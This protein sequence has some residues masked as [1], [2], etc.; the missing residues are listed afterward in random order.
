MSEGDLNG[1]HSPLVLDNDIKQG[2]RYVLP[3]KQR[4][5]YQA[6]E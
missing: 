3:K 2:L 5:Q 4:Q 1:K 6:C